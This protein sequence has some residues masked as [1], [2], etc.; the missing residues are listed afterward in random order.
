M[1]VF[2]TNIWI[3][4]SEN[5]YYF[6]FLFSQGLIARN[7]MLLSAIS[8]STSFLFS[9]ALPGNFIWHTVILHVG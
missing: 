2:P 4:G 7:S 8:K 6:L 9:D 3:P 5:K 1:Y